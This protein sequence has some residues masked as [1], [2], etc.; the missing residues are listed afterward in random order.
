MR[1]LKSSGHACLIL[2]HLLRGRTLTT[3]QAFRLFK[4]TSLHSRLSEL[5]RR[6]WRIKTRP[7]VLR[8]KKR[9]AV[10]SL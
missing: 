2:T 8:S 3:F 1:P 9:I 4:C 7:L 10:Y 6:G 5:R